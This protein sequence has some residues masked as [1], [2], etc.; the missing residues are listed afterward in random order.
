MVK[1]YQAKIDETLPAK[2]TKPKIGSDGDFKL[3]RTIKA[4]A[5]AM[6]T[7]VNELS[8]IMSESGGD[9][10]IMGDFLVQQIGSSECRKS[11]AMRYHWLTQ[12]QNPE[13]SSL[14]G[15]EM[16]A[17]YG[18]L[19]KE[20]RK[21]A[22]TP[23]DPI[24]RANLEQGIYPAWVNKLNEENREAAIKVIGGNLFDE[25]PA[26]EIRNSGPA[27]TFSLEEMKAKFEK[28]CKKFYDGDQEKYAK[29]VAMHKAFVAVAL[30][31][32]DFPGKNPET[33]T[34]TIDR[35]VNSERVSQTQ[36]DYAHQRMQLSFI[37]RR[38]WWK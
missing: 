28:V 32:I 24:Q 12:R 37:Q 8:R 9:Y 1:L 6:E 18:K 15:R 33:S 19:D 16:P 23:L 31:K 14:W 3:T 25:F 22:R 30:D 21:Q 35:V 29:T 27:K 20:D 5:K 17:W 7:A 13:E 10:G 38:F 4:E 11:Q 2:I 36:S 26:Y 34:C